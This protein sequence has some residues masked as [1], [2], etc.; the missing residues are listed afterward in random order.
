MHNQYTDLD[1]PEVHA[2]QVMEIDTLDHAYRSLTMG[3][4]QASR[5]AFFNAR[6]DSQRKQ[7]D[8]RKIRT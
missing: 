5:S 6:C 4:T 3:Y 2:L 7:L 1:L 8:V